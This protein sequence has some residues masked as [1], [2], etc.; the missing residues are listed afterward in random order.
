MEA[1]R[2]G[3]LTRL[4]AG[5]VRALAALPEPLARIAAGRP[6]AIDGQR[7]DPRVQLAL[8]LSPLLGE[9]PLDALG[10][11]RARARILRDARA[12]AGPPVAVAATRELAIRSAR[13]SSIPARLYTP[14]ARDEPRPGEPGGLLL[15]FHG[16]G[17]VVGDLESHDNT[18]RFI[19]R[20]ACVPVLAVEYRRAPEHPFPAA[21]DDA[22]AALRFAVEQA[23]ALGADPRRVAV[24]GDSAGGNLAAVLAQLGRAGEV[25]SPAFQLL[26]YPWLDL[27]RK[28]RSYELFREGFFLT[29]SELDWYRGHYLATGGSAWEGGGD[30]RSSPALAPD[31]RGLAPAYIATAGFDPLRDEAEEYAER[32]RAASVPV[33]LRRHEGLVHGFANTLVLAPARDAL[34][35]A[36]SAMRMALARTP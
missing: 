5:A 17:F 19:A 32:L 22:L 18:C 35:A 7:L 15:Y 36:C 33:V 20:E 1:A 30:V 9:E 14:H 29:E 8:R 21:V 28:H 31:M 23:P 25:P 24:G 11:E 27:T 4:Y 13:G 34:V 16:G 6:V 2:A 26:I 10:V 3:T 12:F